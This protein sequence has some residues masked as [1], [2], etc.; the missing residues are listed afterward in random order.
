ME[1]GRVKKEEK[2]RKELENINEINIIRLGECS[3]TVDRVFSPLPSTSSLLKKQ[4]QNSDLLHFN[5]FSG[6]RERRSVVCRCI[7]NR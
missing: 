6:R 4:S 3:I 5:C 7:S 2:G 1:E